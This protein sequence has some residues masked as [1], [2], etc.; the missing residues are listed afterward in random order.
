MKR[1]LLFAMLCIVGALNISAQG[2]W[3]APA[4]PGVNLS[5]SAPSED[6]YMYNVEADAFVTKGMN[7][8]TN[9]IAMRLKAGDTAVSA[10]QAGRLTITGTTVKFSINDNSGQAVGAGSANANDCW[11]DFGSNQQWTF[12]PSTTVNGAYTLENASF[13]G[14][15]LDVSWKYGGHLTLKDGYG[16]YDWAFITASDIQNGAYAAYKARKEMYA[17]VKALVENDK[18][19]DYATEIA[20][21]V[22]KAFNI[23]FGFAL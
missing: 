15:K 17:I 8:N 5:G 16:N 2:T 14:S 9:A 18:A 7:W 19:V 1:H 20:T 23:S 21:A 3:T 12:T 13:V 4:V 6:V 10:R 11:A 22:K